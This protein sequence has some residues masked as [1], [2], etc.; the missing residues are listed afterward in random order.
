MR[1]R[2]SGAT[3]EQKLEKKRRKNSFFFQIR[4]KKKKRKIQESWQ[5]LRDPAGVPPFFYFLFWAIQQE[6]KN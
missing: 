6:K 2:N 4:Q 1:S 3:V 5:F